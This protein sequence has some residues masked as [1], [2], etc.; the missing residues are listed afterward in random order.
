M[1]ASASS[2][3]LPVRFTVIVPSM[4]AFQTNY[5]IQTDINESCNHFPL[6]DFEWSAL[7]ILLPAVA[8]HLSYGQ[9]VPLLVRV[10][11]FCIA[12]VRD[13]RWGSVSATLKTPCSM[14]YC[15]SFGISQL[16]N[17]YSSM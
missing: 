1:H 6:T 9:R 11:S 16:Q 5:S 8:I 3:D 2:Y 10:E 14:R 12:L 13:A 15:W 4:D 17:R 7:E